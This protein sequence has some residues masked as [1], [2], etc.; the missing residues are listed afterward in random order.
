MGL[1]GGG[2][3][4]AVESAR[5]LQRK[6]AVGFRVV[7]D[8]YVTDDSGTGIVHQAPA[9]GEDDYRYG[10]D[11]DSRVTPRR[12]SAPP[13]PR[14]ACSVAFYACHCRVCLHYGIITKDEPIVC[15][16]DEVG[17][18]TDEVP[19]FAHTNVKVCRRRREREGAARRAA[20]GASSHR[21][22]H[23]RRSGRATPRH[24]TLTKRSS[25]T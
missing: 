19:D 9:F 21:H 7:S 14:A 17:S 8:T 1:G 15:P 20:G 25:S 3:D 10:E 11:T 16:V 6:K 22:A 12:G 18:F 5:L 4:V 2:G 23:G 24:R 13:T